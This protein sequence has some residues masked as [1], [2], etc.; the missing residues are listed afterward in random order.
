MKAVELI[1]ASVL[2]NQLATSCG[3][4]MCMHEK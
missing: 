3:G 2:K 4:A 1:L